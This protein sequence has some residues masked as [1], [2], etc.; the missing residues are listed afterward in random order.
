MNMVTIKDVARRAG[1]STA[2]V[3]RVLNEHP[4]IAQD[5]RQKVHDAIEELG[6]RPNAIA[7][8]LRLTSTSTLG[9]VLS[10]IGN[11]FFA[12]LARAVEDEARA[13]GYA[14]I[15]GNAD[16]RPEQQDHYV[17]TLLERRVDGLLIVPTADGSQLVRDAVARGDHIVQVDREVPDLAAPIVRVDGTSAVR[18]L[19]DHLVAL[20]HERIGLIAGPQT[21]STGRERFAAF[22]AALSQHGLPYRDE[23]VRFG[24][25]HHQSGVTATRELMGLAEPPSAIFASGN[26]QGLGALEE[27]STLGLAVPHDV[28]LAVFDDLAWFSLVDPPVTAIR[29]PTRKL[30]RAAV[31]VLLGQ[32]RG[33]PFAPP[34]LDAELVTRRS[35]G[36]GLRAETV[37]AAG[38]D[39]EVEVTR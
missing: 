14:V 17:Q 28:G 27:L 20:G 9:L 29:Q 35:C 36:E 24:D 4:S 3:S 34:A 11:P 26:P 5:A 19:V 12:E 7:R 18:D 22:R 32:M 31:N 16:E 39:R 37:R 13:N 21:T 2:T 33:Q 30:G 6:Y 15:I 8:S 25:F 1:V 10:S 23:L 38:P